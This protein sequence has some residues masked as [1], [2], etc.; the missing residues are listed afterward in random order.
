[1]SAGF[2]SVTEVENSTDV[3]QVLRWN[4]FLPRAQNEEDFAA[5]TAIVNRLGELRAQD[6]AAYVAASKSIG[7]EK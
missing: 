1:M 3:E 6:L 2:P 5:V 4:R 7:W